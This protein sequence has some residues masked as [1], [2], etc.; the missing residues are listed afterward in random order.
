MCENGKQCN[1][2][3]SETIHLH[4]E[5]SIPPQSENLI[6]HPQSGKS[7]DEGE[8]MPEEGHLGPATHITSQL[9]TGH[10]AS[11][12]GQGGLERNLVR[13]VFPEKTCQRRQKNYRQ[14]ASKCDPRGEF[15]QRKHKGNQDERSALTDH[16][17]KQ[18]YH[19]R[20]EN[21]KRFVKRDLICLDLSLFS[22]LRHKHEACG[23]Q[24]Q[25]SKDAYQEL[26]C[27]K[28][29]EERSDQRGNE[30]RASHADN[31]WSRDKAIPT[32]SQS[33]GKARKESL[34]DSQARDRF[35]VELA[36]LQE[37][38]EVEESGSHDDSASDSQQ[39]GKE[40]D[41]HSYEENGE[42]KRDIY[43]C[44]CNIPQGVPPSVRSA[45]P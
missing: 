5:D 32:I 35:H 6:P 38:K 28:L 4:M 1:T 36:N 39:S 14:V 42:Q 18:P 22:C 15:E 7:D 13:H 16:P 24:S 26:L 17:P 23:D 8:E 20:D 41:H 45:P 43:R 2:T 10:R 29:R 9:R 33:G 11:Y 3:G 40:A 31:Q 30:N 44:H 34:G 37:G 25:G 21:R 19:Q 27:N 12:K